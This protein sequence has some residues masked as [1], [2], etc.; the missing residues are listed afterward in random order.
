VKRLRPIELG[1]FN[2]EKE[3]E[4][5]SL[6]IAEGVTEY[7]GALNLHR[8]GLAARE[9]FLDN[10]SG[11]IEELQ[12]TPGRL[13]QS[14]EQASFDA[15]I[16]Y[17]RPDEN[18]AN[19]SISYYTKGAVLGFLLDARI[20]KATGG[21]RGLDDVMRQAYQ[22]FAGTRGYTPADFRAVAESVAGTSLK[23]FWETAVE[24]T[25]ELDYA[26]ALDTFGL[27]F[28]AAATSGRPWLGVVTRNDGGR[29]LVSQVRRD[30]PSL[31]AGLNVDDE[32][33]AL[34][35]FRVRADRLDERIQQYR[36]G[37]KVTMLIARREQLMRI[38]VTLDRE[39]ARSWRLEVSPA[40]STQQAQQ[41]NRWLKP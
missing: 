20:R 11:N 16:K 14:A 30:G 5:R 12:T 40:S 17:Y 31:K 27:R 26:D 23:S 8:A 15:W 9:E 10:L 34:D 24:G 37:D 22:R 35:E 25:D 18:S 7:Y 38:D 39:P 2:Y 36:P 41:L 1:P 3:N 21:A 6:W 19:T 28:R 4:T 29:L 33:L 13:V 32:I